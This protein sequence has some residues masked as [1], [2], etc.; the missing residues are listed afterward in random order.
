MPP[1]PSRVHLLDIYIFTLCL[2]E[3]QINCVCSCKSITACK[4]HQACTKSKSSWHNQVLYGY[5]T[6]IQRMNM[7]YCRHGR[8][9][10]IPYVT[11]ICWGYDCMQVRPKNFLRFDQKSERH[12][13]TWP[14]QEVRHAWEPS[15]HTQREAL[16]SWVAAQYYQ[17]TQ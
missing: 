5:T 9:G 17:C 7:I 6:P 2:V 3:A 12:N 1:S 13:K 16:Q 8:S 4:L 10:S 11:T 14:L 15:H